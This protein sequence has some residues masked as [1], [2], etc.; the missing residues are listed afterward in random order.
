MGNVT[1]YGY[2]TLFLDR[3]IA[4]SGARIRPCHFGPYVIYTETFKVKAG[5]T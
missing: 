2:D 5:R 4:R 1:S 3:A